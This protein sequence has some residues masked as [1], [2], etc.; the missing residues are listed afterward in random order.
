M[1]KRLFGARLLDAR[2]ALAGKNTMGGRR[3]DDGRGL[4][5]RQQMWKVKF[6]TIRFN[7]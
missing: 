3:I 1:I 6:L 5:I 7:S 4:F 2:L